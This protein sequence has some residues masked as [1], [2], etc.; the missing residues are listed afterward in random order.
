MRRRPHRPSPNP[1]L[2]P[3][4]PRRLLTGAKSDRPLRAP[5]FYAGACGVYPLSNHRIR[6]DAVTSAI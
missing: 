1:L 2:R 5:A 6:D 4:P 3:N